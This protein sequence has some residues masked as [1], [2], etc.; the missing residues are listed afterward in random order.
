M[1]NT[2]V[3]RIVFLQL[4]PEEHYWIAIEF[5]KTVETATY[6]FDMAPTL[7]FEQQHCNHSNNQD[8]DDDGSWKSFKRIRG[9]EKSQMRHV[10]ELKNSFLK[11][12]VHKPYLV[13]VHLDR[14]DIA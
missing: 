6:Y 12:F 11:V 10:E 4:I 8:L 7:D 1:L 9:L 5:A 3:R 13:L 2:F 14:V